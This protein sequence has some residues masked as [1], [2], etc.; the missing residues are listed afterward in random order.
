MR[1]FKY[2]KGTSDKFWHIDLKGNRFTVHFGRIGTDGQKQVKTFVNERAAQKAYER[3]VTEKLIK[4]YKEATKPPTPP[5]PPPSPLRLSLE[6]ALVD[7]PDD[8]AT[9]MAYA[10]YLTDQGDP[11]GEFVRVQLALEDESKPKAERDK[12]KK[13]EAALLR[14]N[15]EA[16]LGDLAPLVQTWKKSK[17]WGDLAVKCTF[18]RG[19][20]DTLTVG[21]YTL[22][23]VR[24]LA[25]APQLR[26][27]RTLVLYNNDF[28]H[29]E[30]LPE[31]GVPSS[32]CD[33]PALY[34][35]ARSPYLSNVRMFIVGEVM[36]DKEEDDFEDGGI[37]CYT[38][39]DGA[40]E[41]VK[42]MAK[43]EE[44]YLL[45]HNIDVEQLFSLRTLD[46]LRVLMLYHAES[47][48]LA[49]LAK[50]PS[51]GNLT[52][53]LLHPHAIDDDP[54]IREPGVKAVVTSPH[55]RSLTH[56]QLRLSDMGDKGVKTIVASGILKRLQVLDLRHGRVSDEG[57]RLL[58]ACP[59]A[60]NLT[61][62]DLTNN[63]LTEAGVEMLK[64]AGVKVVAKNQ[65]QPTGDEEDD[66]E[67]LYA[68]DFE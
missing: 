65:W 16:W 59:D 42:R 58:A 30:V 64:R 46:R 17:Q 7:N 53:L 8:L 49:R 44:L 33:N 22:E 48:P 39:G 34:P 2:K 61:R 3:L 41:I 18:R 12:L 66:E 63:Y 28:E 5:P 20:L 37:S 68:G 51:L 31:D 9:H 11:L 50:N 52:H 60:K 43:L 25:K 27:L 10:D 13:Q 40:V 32:G 38:Q 23:F 29:G 15:A 24:L 21:R 62:L 47:Y 26:L 54:Y 19:W 35:L 6:A 36:S 14:A 67:Y 4:G 56:L 45:A 55:L 1:T 57:A